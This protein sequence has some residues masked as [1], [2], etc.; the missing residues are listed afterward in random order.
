MKLFAPAKV[1]L[2]LRVLGKRPDGY[3]A[4]ESLMAPVSLCDELTIEITPGTTEFGLTCSDPSIPC[5]GSNL[6]LIAARIF[7]EETGRSLGGKIHIEKHIPHGA[8][9]G[10]GSS[11]AASVLLALNHLA[12]TN[13]APP[14]LERIAAHVG[15]DVPFFIGGTAAWITGRGEHVAPH[16]LPQ[17]Y[18]L[19]L[20]KPPFGISTAWAFSAWSKQAARTESSATTF[21]GVDW[22]NDLETPAFQ[23][24]LLLPVLCQWLSEQAGVKVTRMSGSGSTIFAVCESEAAANSLAALAK[25]HLGDTFFIVSVKTT[26]HGQIPSE[27]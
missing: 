26:G 20:I 6:A 13:L 14:E 2:S 12:E 9:L 4:L 19:V 17:S 18:D 8:G 3:H 11:D 5:D 7:F 25:N 16:V 24:F 21:G 1:N 10:G 15:S 23:K 22:T 27:G